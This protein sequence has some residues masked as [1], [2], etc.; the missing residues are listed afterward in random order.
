MVVVIP[1][2]NEVITVGEVRRA[3]VAGRT[4]HHRPVT[5]DNGETRELGGVANFLKEPV[6]QSLAT[7][8]TKS[9][10]LIEPGH[11]SEQNRV[12]RSKG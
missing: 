10:I 12:G 1:V 9:M 7:F 6:S 4:D 3:V 2:V 8:R 11:G 5:A